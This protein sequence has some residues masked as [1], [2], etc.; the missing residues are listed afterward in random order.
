MKTDARLPYD[1]I[2]ASFLPP[3]DPVLGYIKVGSKDSTVRYTRAGKPWVA[4]T[5]LL[6]PARFEV[7]TREK[8]TKQLKG[9]G[10]AAGQDFTVDLGYVR[11]QAFHDE[12][13]EQPSAL[14]VTFLYP[15]WNQNLISFL[16]AWGGG[17]WA[18]RGNGVE[19]ID[20]KRGKCACPCPRLKQFEGEYDGP[21]LND[22][23]SYKDGNNTWKKDG[24]HVCK[25]HAVLNVILQDA[26]VF[27]GFWPFKTTS[28]E[29]ISNLIKTLRMFE[30]MFKRVDG[31]PLELRVMA[32]TKQ[33]PGGGTTVQPIVTL[34]L[35][36]AMNAARQLAGNAAAEAR[37]FLPAGRKLDEEH[38]REAVVSEMEAE[39]ESYAGEFL[40]V[41][42][43]EVE[44]E[45]EATT[46]GGVVA[47]ELR[48]QEQI[49][50]EGRA[51]EKVVEVVTEIVGQDNPSQETKDEGG[52]G[53]E[54]DEHT[55]EGGQPSVGGSGDQ[56]A[57]GAPRDPSSARSDNST[58]G[59]GR[60]VEGGGRDRVDDPEAV[61]HDDSDR[62]D[63][64]K[65]LE[66]YDRDDYELARKVLEASDDW[67]EEGIKDRL[68]YHRKTG[69][70]DKLLERLEKNLPDAWA[71]VAAPEA[72][73]PEDGL[74]S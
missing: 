39:A 37:K 7:V 32:A 36:A 19:A 52:D 30:E 23:V 41:E 6:D 47:E 8:R 57:G 46:S 60:A 56:R 17:E 43:L 14:R 64:P 72:S 51:A 71:K 2:E 61:E 74:P 15:R 44:E 58:G 65:D 63:E 34:V 59:G 73:E 20:T 69:T 16:G 12:V 3:R 49:Q 22:G 50:A 42:V 35:P 24:L 9:K 38:Y 67:E 55:G 28:F 29:T 68:D 10:N 4:P 27:G 53:S 40:P 66:E 70:L 21:K 26:G 25:P 54:S 11:D 5:R 31:L 62:N 18:C 48:K 13:G 1:Q 33:V 45:E